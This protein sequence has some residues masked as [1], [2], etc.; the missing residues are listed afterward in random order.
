MDNDNHIKLLMIF[1]CYNEEA[2]LPDST[3]KIFNYFEDLINQNM[4]SPK[5]RICFVD[6]G[7]QD[8]TW[9]IISKI[10]K[11]Y[12]NAVKLSTNFGHQKALLAGLSTFV[13]Q[14]DAYVT[15][16]VDLQDDIQVVTKMIEKFKENYEII[17]GV[18]SDRSN[19]NFFKRKTA[20][21]FYKLF[22]KM[23]VKTVYNHADFRLISNRALQHFLE[24]NESH[25]FLR[26]IFPAIG[27]KHTNVYYKRLKRELGESKY[28]LKKMLAFAW[29]GITSFS[30]A[31]LKFVLFIGLLAIVI[32]IGLLTWASVQ[33]LLGNTITGWYSTV[34]LIIFFGGLQT[35]AIGIIGEYIG[36]IFIQTK[37][38]P[39]FLIE[40]IIKR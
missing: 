19:D 17:Y 39:R 38:R 37:N 8:K 28:P 22:E 32:S 1:P 35:F 2:V 16:D 20:E 18:R 30:V 7:S 3:V 21:T 26:A 15:L 4:I 23:G 33:L 11:P 40:K 5:S 10:E 36:K 6:D 25:L 9:N 27:L 31:P 14:F 13:N 29:D 34:T 12:I 24:F